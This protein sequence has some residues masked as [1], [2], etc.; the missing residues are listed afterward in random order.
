M[1]G[2]ASSKARVELNFAAAVDLGA[3]LITVVLL[4]IKGS[5][6]RYLSPA[7]GAVDLAS[8]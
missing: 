4:T 7:G 6:N 2:D 1:K 3:G 8:S 5:S